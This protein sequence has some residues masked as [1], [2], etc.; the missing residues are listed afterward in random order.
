ME[1]LLQ[2]TAHNDNCEIS[3]TYPEQGRPTKDGGYEQMILGKW[4]QVSPIDKS[5]KFKCTCGLSD[6]LKDLKI[7]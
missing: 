3:Q 5:P 1:R 4:Y 6:V 7:G 2:Y